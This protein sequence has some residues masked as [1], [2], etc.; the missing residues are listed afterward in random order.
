MVW[1]LV[2]DLQAMNSVI[3]TTSPILLY[4]LLKEL[5]SVKENLNQRLDGLQERLKGVERRLN[6]HAKALHERRNA[7]E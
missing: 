5:K 1:E 4:L 3:Q 6:I 2:T 7:K